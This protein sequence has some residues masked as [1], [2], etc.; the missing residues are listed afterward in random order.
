MNGARLVA[1]RSPMTR[2]PIVLRLALV[3]GAFLPFLAPSHAAGGSR[4]VGVIYYGGEWENLLEGL[5]QGLRELGVEEGKHIVFDVRDAK[6]DLKAVEVAARALEAAKVDLIITPSTSVTSAARRATTQVPL[7]FFAGA[8]PV[9]AGL[10]ES[11]SKPGA[12]L[13]GIHGLTRD[14]TVKRMEVLKLLLPKLS[15]AVTIYNP[16][17]PIA[18]SAARAAREE[19][20]RA[21]VQLTERHVRSIDELRTIAQGIK[22]QEFEAF[23]QISDAL[24]TA[25]AST[26]IE[27]LREK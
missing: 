15:R 8:D 27:I 19:A 25:Q 6:G 23:F 21:H 4:R 22:P 2:A 7:V 9:A 14:L 3:L 10:V 24:I 20:K 5:R 26:I 18:Q 12:R 13:T 16:D 11:Y 17:N 1:V